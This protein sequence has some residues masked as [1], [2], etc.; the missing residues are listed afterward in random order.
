M[1][2]EFKQKIYFCQTMEKDEI[3]AAKFWLIPR[4]KIYFQKS[5]VNNNLSR[6]LVHKEFLKPAPR[7]SIMWFLDCQLLRAIVSGILSLNLSLGHLNLVLKHNQFLPSL[8]KPGL[9]P[10][11]YFSKWTLHEEV[12]GIPGWRREEIPSVS[13][14]LSYWEV[15]FLSYLRW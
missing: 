11:T 7:F 6:V 15:A 1:K 13:S 9:Y 12:L 3:V 4:I 2:I 14:F 5:S 10:E 8:M